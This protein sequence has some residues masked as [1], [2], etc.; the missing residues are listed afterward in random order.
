LNNLYELYSFTQEHS[1]IINSIIIASFAVIHFLFW[2][3][4]SIPCLMMVLIAL[5]CKVYSNIPKFKP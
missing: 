4:S 2:S 3:F 1:A 5:A